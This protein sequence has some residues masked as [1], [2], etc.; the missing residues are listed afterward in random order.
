MRLLLKKI[1]LKEQTESDIEA[2]FY[3]VQKFVDYIKEHLDKANYLINNKILDFDELELFNSLSE[4]FDIKFDDND[5]LEMLSDK[6]DMH[7]TDYV[8]LNTNMVDDE[9]YNIS[10]VGVKTKKIGNYNGRV[11]LNEI[12]KITNSY[13]FLILRTKRSKLNFDLKG[14]ERFEEHQFF[15]FDKTINEGNELFSYATSLLRRNIHLKNVLK[16]ILSDVEVYINEL[17]YQAKCIT[18][19]SELND[20]PEL[21]QAGIIYKIAFDENFVGKQLKKSNHKRRY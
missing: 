11:S 16:K 15:D 13:D 18:K 21:K 17:M 7:Y 3:D 10:Y 20:N 9:G 8:S 14:K 5:Y 4:V 12:R 6:F 19:L 1:D 2:K